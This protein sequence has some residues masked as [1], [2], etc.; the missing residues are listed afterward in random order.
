MRGDASGRD[1]RVQN[2][3]KGNRYIVNNILTLENR[4]VAHAE[5][6]NLY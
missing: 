2:A 1:W 4:V 6:T 5:L 3:I